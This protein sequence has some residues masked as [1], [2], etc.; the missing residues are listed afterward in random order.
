MRN[1]SSRFALSERKQ[2]SSA[3]QLHEETGNCECIT[4]NYAI[5]E[6]NADMKLRWS[7][8]NWTEAEEQVSRLQIRIV[9]AT[10]EQ[11]WRLVKRL[12]YLMTNSFY[13]KAIA[14]KRVITNKGKRTPG[15]DGEL[16]KTDVEKMKAVNELNCQTYHAKPLKRIYIEKFGKT[17]KRPLGIPTMRDRAMQA[18]Q[19]L[20]LE[21]VAETTADRISFGFRKYRS[22]E[23]A[24]E[25]AFRILSRKD[26]PQWIL[27]GDIKS[28]FDKISHEWM[29]EHIPTDKRILKE[30]M[31]CGYI[32]K[33]KLYPTTEG[34]P[35]GGVISPTYANMVLDGMEP[36][37]LNVYWRSK[38]KKTFGVKYNS[39]K[40]HMV[41]FAD[42]FIVTASDKETLEAIKQMLESF[43]RERGLTLSMEKTVITHIN[44]GFDFLGWN[45]RKFKGKLIIKPSSKSMRKVTKKISEIIKNNRTTKQ[46]ILIQRLNQVLIGWA[47][48][49]QGTCAKKCFG[50]IDNRTWKM[51]WKWAKRRH[52][53]KKHQWIVDKYWK[54]YKGR[55][56]AF[57]TEKS[58]LFSMSDMPI[59]RK[60]QMALD[61]NA[62]LD[63]EYF[64]KR[65][66]KHRQ[67]RKMAMSSNNA[68]HIGIMCYRCVSG[69]Q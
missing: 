45:F 24:R 51:L 11:K 8:I 69:M 50:T 65:S 34:S 5:S 33:G 39:H 32:N 61:K 35:Q 31:K 23:D 40:V 10:L 27:E 41:R 13:A 19:L 47:N 57:R 1:R 38:V 12:Q 42:D 28:C 53:N 68:A 7:Q 58:I 44:S 48:Y 56:W 14:V 43:L 21:P 3:Y 46:E 63:K 29:M 9:K 18:L 54:E 15:I 25:Y 4:F 67:K 30:F 16:W 60:S 62:F 37:I 64:Q 66:Q 17:E 22:P 6:D 59:V 36:M 49:H 26:S 2:T 52:P 20:A 55:R